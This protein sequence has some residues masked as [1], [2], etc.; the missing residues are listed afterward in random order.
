MLNIILFLLKTSFCSFGLILLKKSFGQNENSNLNFIDLL[1]N[2][3]FLFGFLLYSG[4][5]FLWLFLLSRLNL[6]VAFPINMSL[7]FIFTSFGSYY[8]LSEE[9]HTSHILGII[10]CALGIVMIN[11]SAK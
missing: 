11:Y 6:N 7:I 1:F 5:F 3:N 9:I 8:F 2:P 10:L 4:S